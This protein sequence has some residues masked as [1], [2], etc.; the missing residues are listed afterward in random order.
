LSDWQVY[1]RSI[2]NTDYLLLNSTAAKTT[3]ATR[4]NSTTATATHFSIG[5]D[6]GSV[7]KNGE[8]YVA[9]LF[10]HET[11]G[12]IQCGSYTGNGN[13]TGPIINL[14]WQP[15]FLLLKNATGTGGWLMLDTARGITTPGSDVYFSANVGNAEVSTE[16]LNLTNDGFQLSSNNSAVNSS[17]ATY[18]YCAIKAETPTH[19]PTWYSGITYVGD[20]GLTYGGTCTQPNEA[21][22]NDENTGSKYTWGSKTITNSDIQADLGSVKTVSLIRLGGNGA[23][24]CG[25]GSC[26]SY[27]NEAVVELQ[28]SNDGSS[29]TS[30][31]TFSSLAPSFTYTTAIQTVSFTPVTARYWRLYGASGWTCTGQ[32]RLGN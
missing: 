30:L 32:F 1:H 23:L 2:P 4:W 22:M 27:F 5:T 31:G 19:I 15:Q 3:G 25:W 6:Q 26:P 21:L 14:G 13:A 24:S 28:H 29:W 8:D 10:A 7:N 11:S 12:K 16:Y 18:V 20:G 9:Y 17:G